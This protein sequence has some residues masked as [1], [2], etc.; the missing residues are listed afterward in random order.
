MGDGSSIV[1][2]EDV[3]QTVFETLVNEYGH[4]Q[5]RKYT[6]YAVSQ[7]LTELMHYLDSDQIIAL[8]A[9]ADV[10]SE[11]ESF[12]G[13]QPPDRAAYCIDL[14]ECLTT[15]IKLHYD[16][17]TYG[18][19]PWDDVQSFLCMETTP[20][21]D[22]TVRSLTVKIDS[23]QLRNQIRN[24]LTDM[25]L[26][27]TN[28]L[29]CPFF[30]TLQSRPAKRRERDKVKKHNDDDFLSRVGYRVLELQQMYSL[31]AQQDKKDILLRGKSDNLYPRGLED[32]AFNYNDPAEQQFGALYSNLIINKWRAAFSRNLGEKT[33]M[34]WTDDGQW[35]RVDE[36]DAA[37]VVEESAV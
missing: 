15:K 33:P 29:K 23:Q 20:V 19:F 6:G 18:M 2:V 8:K 12:R 24:V 30:F 35:K 31:R 1:Q 13:M 9:V 22:L 11:E 25:G 5:E 14:R 32:M 10:T 17:A 34:V 4:S 26:T 16:R 3:P 37:S 27:D 7:S 21:D 36:R 28:Y